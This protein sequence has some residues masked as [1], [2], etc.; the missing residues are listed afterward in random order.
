V[1]RGPSTSVWLKICI[2]LLVLAGAAWLLTG[3]EIILGLAAGMAGVAALALVA[4]LLDVLGVPWN[5]WR[6]R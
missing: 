4:D 5:R 3:S 2:F 6:D 1:D